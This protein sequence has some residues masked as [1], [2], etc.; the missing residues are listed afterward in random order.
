MSCFSC[1]RTLR[2]LHIGHKVRPLLKA[3]AYLQGVRWPGIQGGF[4]TQ[5]EGMRLLL[6]S[7]LL[8]ETSH[9]QQ[10]GQLLEVQPGGMGLLLVRGR[11]VMV[12]SIRLRLFDWMDIPANAQSEHNTKNAFP[13]SLLARPKPPNFYFNPGFEFDTTLLTPVDYRLRPSHCVAPPLPLCETRT[14]SLRFVLFSAFL[15]FF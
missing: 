7:P 8:S 6:M 9:Q 14:H 3:F 1:F 4:R 15:H 5:P 10:P 2:T 12:L 11:E 13:R